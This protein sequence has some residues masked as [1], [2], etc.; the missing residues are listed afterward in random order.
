[1]EASTEKIEVE[2]AKERRDK[3]WVGK[4]NKRNREE[5]TQKQKMNNIMEVKLVV[6]EW[7]IWN[8]KKE[9]VRYEKNQCQN[10]LI[11]RFESLERKKVNEWPPEKCGIMWLNWK[12]NFYQEKRSIP[13]FGTREKTL[14]SSYKSSYTRGILNSPSYF[15]Q[16]QCSL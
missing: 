15:R 9:M 5:I 3:E 13:Y 6:K 11:S 2:K 10:S 16:H 8:K 7:K 4:M 1:M 12:R 14:R